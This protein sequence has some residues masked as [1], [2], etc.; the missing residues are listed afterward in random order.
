MSHSQR[1]D[2]AGLPENCKTQQDAARRRKTPPDAT[3]PMKNVKG[4]RHNDSKMC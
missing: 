3:D 4:I 1:L 2:T